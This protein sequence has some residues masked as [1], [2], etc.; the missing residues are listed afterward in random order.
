VA[1]G[2]TLSDLRTR[3]LHRI[4]MTGSSY[5]VNAR[6]REHINDALSGLYELLADADHFSRTSSAISLVSG[7]KV[8][9]LPGD[10][11]RVQEVRYVTGDRTYPLREWSRRELHGVHSSPRSTGS[12]EVDYVPQ[13]VKLVDD[14]D[15]VDDAFAYGAALPMGWEG[16]V[17][18]RAA[19]PELAREESDTSDLKAEIADFQAR[20][21]GQVQRR[22][23]GRVADVGGRWTSWF[24]SGAHL[25]LYYRVVGADLHMIEMGVRGV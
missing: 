7:T 12:V 2:T 25:G 3:V 1:N 10:L 21:T 17:A 8:Y 23:K 9:S 14:G 6:I 5:P 11:Y 4:D 16:Y 18:A 20:V 24:A 15:T 22:S 19:L 13:M